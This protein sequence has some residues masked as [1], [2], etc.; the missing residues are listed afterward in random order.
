MNH[1]ISSDAIIEVD[2]ELGK[3]TMNIGDVTKPT[4]FGDFFEGKLSIYHGNIE[5]T[6]NC[7]CFGLIYVFSGFPENSGLDGCGFAMYNESCSLVA[8]TDHLIQ[9][10]LEHHKRR[11]LE[12][13]DASTTILH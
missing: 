13:R 1:P 2:D 6:L 5:G 3:F 7:K 11:I 10:L 12:V 8:A 9:Q 4:W